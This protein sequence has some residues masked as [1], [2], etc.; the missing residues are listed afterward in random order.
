MRAAIKFPISHL[1]SLNDERD[2]VVQCAV[3]HILGQLLL[4]DAVLVERGHK[5]SEGARHA[6]LEVQAA[7]GEDKRILEA[8]TPL[9]SNHPAK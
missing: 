5:I 2:N 8:S 9:E 4:L 1:Y 3:S 6:E 7:S